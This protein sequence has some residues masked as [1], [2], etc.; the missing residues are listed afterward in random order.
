MLIGKILTRFF[1]LFTRNKET[2]N[3]CYIEL[4]YTLNGLMH[5]K[6]YS[7]GT[8]ATCLQI[9]TTGKPSRSAVITTHLSWLVMNSFY[10]YVCDLN[11]AMKHEEQ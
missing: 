10:M 11:E 6:M 5:L 1:Q 4:G 2:N 3:V 8:S 9:I 7:R